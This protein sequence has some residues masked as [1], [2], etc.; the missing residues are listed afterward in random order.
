M[1]K[2]C[3]NCLYGNEPIEFKGCQV[4]IESECNSGWKPETTGIEAMVCA[5]IAERQKLGILK[6]Q[7]T[8]KDNPLS[9]KQWLQHAYEEN[10]D[11]AVY[12]RRAIAEIETNE[13]Q[14]K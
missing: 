10:L 2:D 12:L 5:D 7:T 3:D 11:S 6:Y 13:T 9:L 14:D 8:V 4:C 1:N